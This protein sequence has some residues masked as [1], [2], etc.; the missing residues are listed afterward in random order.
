[1]PLLLWGQFSSPFLPDFIDEQQLTSE[2]LLALESYLDNPRDLNRISF[3]D[4][5]FIADSLATLIVNTRQARPYRS[6][7]DM[8]RRTQLPES[9]IQEL[10]LM[11]S[12]QQ[13]QLFQGNWTTRLINSGNDERIRSRIHVSRRF[14]SAQ[15]TLQRDPG[16]YDLTDLSA[17]SLGVQRGNTTLIIGSQRIEWGQGLV[18]SKA[19]A[20]RRGIALLRSPS[21]IMRIRPGYSN[22]NSG[23][24][25]GISLST[26]LGRLRVFCGTGLHKADVTLTPSG[27]PKIVAYRTHSHPSRQ[28]YEVVPWIGSSTAFKQTSLG[29]FA[30]EQYLMP[31]DTLSGYRTQVL[32]LVLVKK[33]VAAAGTW[34][35]RHEEAW[36]SQGYREASGKQ[37]RATQTRVLFNSKVDSSGK[38]VRLTMIYRAYPHRWVPIRGQLFGRHTSNG[39]ERGLYLGWE[40]SRNPFSLTGH[41][42]YFQ[43][44]IPTTGLW[45]HRGWESSLS[46]GLGGKSCLTR[47]TYRRK[48]EEVCVSSETLDGLTINTHV[49]PVTTYTSI[50]YSGDLGLHLS[51]RIHAA[52]TKND[53]GSRSGN[54]IGSTLRYY[55]RSKTSI[56]AG[57]YLFR[58]DG[59]DQR[60]M[61]YEA[62]LPRE[63]NM[64]PL[65]GSG[66]R[67]HGLIS[68]PMDNG[69]ISFRAAKEW[70]E[71]DV[72]SETAA[73]PL[74][75]GIQIDIAL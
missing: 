31:D 46:A 15:W 52:R 10:K 71:A 42:D 25:Q 22:I 9:M 45:P 68:I 30:G 1:M 4:L 36:Q 43:Q 44:V 17:F 11:F 41:M 57:A 66:L 8:A 48:G 75:A 54:A 61:I 58:T 24:I 26:Q 53:T 72:G 49:E 60:I 18:L 28:Q 32:S 3:Q 12:L 70:K 55:T 34:Q 35:L 59:W 29:A 23:A 73:S 7:E 14:W 62:G 69:A 37:L 13:E 74:Q 50:T 67:I 2:E 51:A 33:Y 40:W 38:R 6:W 27:Y 5:W 20:P 63:F 16:E 19:Y 47:L 56:A 21:D 65:Y 64:R 39:N